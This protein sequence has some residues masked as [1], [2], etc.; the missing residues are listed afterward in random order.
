MTPPPAQRSPTTKERED[1][2]GEPHSKPWR[3]AQEQR[4]VKGEIWSDVKRAT[5]EGFLNVMESKS[6][7]K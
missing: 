1:T 7:R 4:L 2:N 5:S 6:G 3:K